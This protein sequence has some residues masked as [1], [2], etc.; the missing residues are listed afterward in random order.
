MRT[1]PARLIQHLP[2][3]EYP[4]LACGNVV[5][6]N[7]PEHKFVVQ[8]EDYVKGIDCPCVVIYANGEYTVR[9]GTAQKQA[10]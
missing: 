6:V 4:A 9:F 8:T 3:G 7:T 10:L 5:V 2:P 1:C